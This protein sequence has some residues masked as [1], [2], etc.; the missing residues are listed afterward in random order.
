MILLAL[1]AMLLI[2]AWIGWL[3]RDLKAE[4]DQYRGEERRDAEWD[5]THGV[6]RAA[7]RGE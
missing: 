4:R 3:L 2:G 1:L 7:S 5:A 6:G